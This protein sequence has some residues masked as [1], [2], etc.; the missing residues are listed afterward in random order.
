MGYSYFY[1]FKKGWEADLGFRYIKAGNDDFKTAVVGIGNYFGSY[2]IN[3]RT[4]IQKEDKN[5]YPAFTLTARYYLETRFDYISAI[6]GYG[7]S[8]DERPTLGQFQQ[9]IALNSYR[10]GVGYF[11]LFNNHYVTGFQTFYNNQ[12]YAP[13]LK[14][15][16]LGFLLLLQY[17][18]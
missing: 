7:T 9:R 13:N 17:K 5:Y 3:F 6:A 1:N 15:N 16:E 18:F 8:P 11:R 12:E 2:W 10:I 14:Q 4:F